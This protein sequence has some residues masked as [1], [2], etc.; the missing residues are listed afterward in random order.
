MNPLEI[1]TTTGPWHIDPEGGKYYGIQVP[2]VFG[3][4]WAKM[5]DFPGPPS[6]Y[7]MWFWGVFSLD[8]EFYSCAACSAGPEAGQIYN[9]AAWAVGIDI[10]DEPTGRPYRMQGSTYPQ[11]VSGIGVPQV[12]RDLFKGKLP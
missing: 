9:C 12:V 7:W 8:Q 1:K 3:D 2:W 11:W 6:W 10:H 5:E 4:Q